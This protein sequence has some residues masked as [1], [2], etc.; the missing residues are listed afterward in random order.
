MHDHITF[1]RAID[2]AGLLGTWKIERL[3]P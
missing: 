3:Q 1:T 2:E